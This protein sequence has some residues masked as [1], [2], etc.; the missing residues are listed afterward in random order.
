MRRC[1]AFFYPFSLFAS[2]KA[3]GGVE[4]LRQEA[5]L[6]EYASPNTMQR[7]EL[8]HALIAT[9]IQQQIEASQAKQLAMKLMKGAENPTISTWLD[10][11]GRLWE[12]LKK[13]G[14]TPKLS[15]SEERIAELKQMMRK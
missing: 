11:T 15:K 7:H 10:D 9:L 4:G 3:K 8:K 14:V 12:A 6:K 1:F 5:K 2:I 13:F